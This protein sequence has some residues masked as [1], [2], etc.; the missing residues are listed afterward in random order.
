MISPSDP[1]DTRT[2][3]GTTPALQEQE[4]NVV[5]RWAAFYADDQ[6]EISNLDDGIRAALVYTLVYNKE[7]AAEAAAAAATKVSKLLSHESNEI[8]KILHVATPPQPVNNLLIKKISQTVKQFALETDDDYKNIYGAR[9]PYRPKSPFQF[10]TEEKESAVR[11]TSY[12]ENP[13]F[14]YSKRC[15]FIKKKVAAMNLPSL[16][17]SLSEHEQIPYTEQAVESAKPVPFVIARRKP[18]K[19]VAVLSHR[20][21][22]AGLQGM[23]CLKG[24]DKMLAQLVCEFLIVSLLFF[25]SFFFFFFFIVSET[26]SFPIIFLGRSI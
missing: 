19:L 17:S 12:K 24:R 15:E 21:T 18:A 3:F 2:Y 11:D 13:D 6:H 22:S 10:Y 20:Y 26:K 7:A 14:G 8:N 25:M 16:W 23:H 5:V 1:S 9:D 4:Q